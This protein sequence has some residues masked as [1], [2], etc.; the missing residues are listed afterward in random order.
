MAKQTIAAIVA[1]NAT[2]LQAM[3]TT[4]ELREVAISKGWN[5]QAAFPRFKKAL[6]E[7]GIDY[8]AMRNGVRSEAV[9]SVAALVTHE[10]TLYSDAKASK[11]RFGITDGSGSPVWYGL[12]FDNDRDYNGEQSS[13]EMAAA[14]KAVWL[15]GQIKEKIGAGA[16]RL[17]LMVDAEWLT[18]ANRV[19]APDDNGKGGGKARVL[20]ELARRSGVVLNVEW[21]SGA[22]NPADAYTICSGFRRWQENDLAGLARPIAESAAA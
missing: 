6:M 13:G 19:G 22:R 9:A 2:E 15:A 12:F 18:Y 14:K 20:G 8:V 16:I 3:T 7:I 4:V 1:E 10:V 17:R 11:N 5:S 21:I